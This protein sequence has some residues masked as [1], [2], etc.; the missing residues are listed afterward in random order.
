MKKG[1]GRKFLQEGMKDG[2]RK[3]D[4]DELSIS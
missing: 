1:K 2:R 4:E 3:L